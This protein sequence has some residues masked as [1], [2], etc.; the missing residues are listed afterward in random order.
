MVGP[1]VSCPGVDAHSIGGIHERLIDSGW[2]PR[3]PTTRSKY[4]YAFAILLATLACAE[5]SSVELP[6]K[7]NKPSASGGAGGKT[8][9][10]TQTTGDDTSG[11]GG[12]TASE[13]NGQGDGGTKTG[14]TTKA[15]SSKGGSTG[16]PQTTT[17]KANGGSD[18]TEGTEPTSSGGASEG[19]T[20]TPAPTGS[21]ENSTKQVDVAVTW[22]K[23]GSSGTT[24]ITPAAGSTISVKDLGL[25][26]CFTI[27]SKLTP[28]AMVIS[29]GSISLKR[30]P[31]TVVLSSAKITLEDGSDGSSC[32][33]VDVAGIAAAAS[34]SMDGEAKMQLD[35]RF[36][37]NVVGS[38]QPDPTK[39]AQ[40]IVTLGS[41]IAGCGDVPL[42]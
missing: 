17:A 42:S 8:Q 35:W 32:L 29:Y 6:G 38:S 4:S 37:Y 31:Y 26:F 41:D 39:P 24:A 25:K 7:G 2:S 18:S 27:S 3:M 40:W 30:E 5:P 13:T 19:T 15:V 34:I 14:T 11:S 1:G 28:A 36:D 10:T 33:V 9:K 20:T 22:S 12:S 21:C 23:S 16:L